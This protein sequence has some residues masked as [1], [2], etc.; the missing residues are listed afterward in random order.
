[1]KILFVEIKHRLTTDGTYKIEAE[2]KGGLYNLLKL[3]SS[4]EPTN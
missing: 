4:E 2:N 3:K 1:M